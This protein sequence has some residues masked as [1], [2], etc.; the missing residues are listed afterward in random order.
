VPVVVTDLVCVVVPPVHEYDEAVGT[1]KVI[2]V[3]VHVNV[4]ILGDSLIVGVGGVV[5]I[6]IAWLSVAVHP[7]V[8]VTVT[9]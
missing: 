7:L 2:V 4:V 5:L 6:V 9:T 8:P 1:D 3:V